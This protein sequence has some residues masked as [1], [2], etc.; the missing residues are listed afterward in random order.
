MTLKEQIEATIKAYELACLPENLNFE[1]CFKN[2][3]ESG[4]CLY[5]HINNYNE[6]FYRIK[7]YYPNKYLCS[8]PNVIIFNKKI[9][10]DFL[11]KIHKTRINFLKNL[12][13]T[14]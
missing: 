8:P 6:L 1:Y 2:N 5:S 11:I 4:I 10:S 9:A 12:L 14:I 3:L 13:K 7:Y